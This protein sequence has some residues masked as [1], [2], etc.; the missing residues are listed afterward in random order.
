MG[1]AFCVS[2]LFPKAAQAEPVLFLLLAT[3]HLRSLVQGQYFK[4]RANK[5]E[6]K[7]FVSL[8]HS[9]GRLE[10][11]LG[12]VPANPDHR[13][14]RNVFPGLRHCLDCEIFL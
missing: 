14:F 2:L 13:F 12:H 8:K 6:S 5:L 9:S 4:Q 7:Q 3:N 1:C 11:L 10:R